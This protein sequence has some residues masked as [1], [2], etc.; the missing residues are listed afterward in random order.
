MTTTR[1]A[2]PFL[3]GFVGLRLPDAVDAARCEALI[4]A[5][6]Q[7]GFAATGGAYPADYRDND[8]LV[9]DDDALAAALFA[10]A[11]DRVPATLVEDGA[12]W[13]LVG[14]NR[15]FRACRYRDGQ[16]FCV[17]RDGA[18][19]PT[20]ELRSWLTFQIYLDDGDRFTGGRTRFYADRGGARLLAAIA[21]VRGT[22]IVFDHRAWHD[23]EP[24]TAGTKMVLRTDV[25]YRRGDAA[26]AVD[27]RRVIGRHRGYVWSVIAR[28]DGA[29]ASAGRDG[30]VRVWGR[31]GSS[32]ATHD[33][34]SGSVTA[35]AESRDGRLWCGT[36]GGRLF[37]IDDV[38]RLVAGELDEL[39]AVLGLRAFAGGVALAS[40]RGDVMTFDADGAPRRRVRAHQGWA[41]AVVPA[42]DA[43]ISCGDD[44]NVVRIDREGAT[45]VI[46]SLGARLRAI[47]RTT[48]GELLVGDGDGVVTRLDRDGAIVDRVVA[49]DA[50]ITALAVGPDDRWISASEDQ[51][52]ICWRDNV[53]AGEWTSDDFVTSLAIVSD[54]V[55]CS[56]YD[57]A[58]WS[59]PIAPISRIAPEF[60]N[61]AR[62]LA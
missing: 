25:M 52:V 42:G 59:T 58:V 26:R 29:L 28:A 17:H 41:W 46:A 33:L 27:P 45:H 51:R 12:T 50:V 5:I 9:F 53:R 55:V 49:H 32:R 13:H 30:T 4:A 18:F 7:R 8:R 21:P 20:D 2:V 24:V 31:D 22:A 56:G 54:G 57:G 15:R 1:D 62:S 6:E 40:S 43:L 47:A 3:D 60:S 48:T 39:G 61:D 16:R 44:G 38:A 35:L 10:A 14:F 34:A 37:V 11:R 19:V 23:G 36:R